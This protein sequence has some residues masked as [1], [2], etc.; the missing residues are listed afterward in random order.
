[1]LCSLPFELLRVSIGTLDRLSV[2]PD[3]EQ[4]NGIFDFFK[5]QA[6]LGIGFYG[7]TCLPQE[8]RPSSFLFLK[9]MGLANKIRINNDSLNARCL[10]LCASLA[11]DGFD[12]CILKG[13]ANY[14]YYPITLQGYRNPGDIDIWVRPEGEH[15]NK[16]RIIEYVLAHTDEGLRASVYNDLKQHHID[17]PCFR[18]T[19]VEV[20]FIP[21]VLNSPCA[22]KKLKEFFLSHCDYVE[23]SSLGIIVPR[24]DFNLVYQ[25]VHVYRHLFTSGVGLRQLM[26]YY[27]ALQHYSAWN[28]DNKDACNKMCIE[29]IRAQIDKLG[30]SRFASALMYVLQQIFALHDDLLLCQP[31][32][33][34]GEF[35]LDEIMLSGNFGKYDPRYNAIQSASKWMRFF[36]I[37]RRNWHFFSRYPSEVFWSPFLRAY[38]VIWRRLRLWR[39]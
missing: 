7:I 14:D 24:P 9:W 15:I 33:E 17:F 31:D 18:D 6:L 28:T 39:W 20:H 11:R 37:T 21:S 16:K 35:L 36:L 12:T 23:K 25:L 1:M 27:Y 5:K 32:A 34:E 2:N 19:P 30:M 8:Q 22:R 13:Q 4:W 38:N 3:S 10:E 26:D 29:E